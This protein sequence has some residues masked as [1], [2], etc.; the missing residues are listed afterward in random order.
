MG[1]VILKLGLN[2]LKVWA[3][4]AEDLLED[5]KRINLFKSGQM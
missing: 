4:L 5:F 2:D 3:F 1:K